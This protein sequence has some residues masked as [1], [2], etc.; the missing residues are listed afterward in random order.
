MNTL[1]MPIE[2]V[3]SSEAFCSSL[4]T[5]YVTLEWFQMLE[6]MFSVASSQRVVYSAAYCKPTCGLSCTSKPPHTLGT[7]L[8]Y[9]T[10]RCDY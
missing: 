8:V 5:R 10:F 2:I 3:G 6:Y 9:S 1:L 7:A 4:A